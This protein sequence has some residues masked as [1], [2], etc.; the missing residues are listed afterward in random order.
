[1]SLG[2]RLIKLQGSNLDVA[3]DLNIGQFQIARNEDG[4]YK[5]NADGTYQTISGGTVQNVN[6]KS[7][8]LKE[9]NWEIHKKSSFNI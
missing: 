6:I 1:M 8:E 7:A 4:S 3:Q 2:I 9:I 5:T